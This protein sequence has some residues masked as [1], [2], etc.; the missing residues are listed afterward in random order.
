MTLA[1]R[2][3]GILRPS[4]GAAWEEG[5]STTQRRGEGTWHASGRK[6]GR[7]LGPPNKQPGNH[8]PWTVLGE[9][10]KVFG[11]NFMCN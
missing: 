9:F 6:K 2:C 5:V 7:F 11:S 4:K 8:I 10:R 1:L 3:E